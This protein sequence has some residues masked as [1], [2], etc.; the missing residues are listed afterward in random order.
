[1]LDFDNTGQMSLHAFTGPTPFIQIMINLICSVLP[2]SH[3]IHA[4]MEPNK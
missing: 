1:M 2:V 3:V 4:G